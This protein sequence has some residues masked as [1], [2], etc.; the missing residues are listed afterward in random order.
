METK[1]AEV[2]SRFVYKTPYAISEVISSCDATSPMCTPTLSERILVLLWPSHLCDTITTLTKQVGDVFECG[3]CLD[4]CAGMLASCHRAAIR[5]EAA[6]IMSQLFCCAGPW[7][8]GSWAFPPAASGH[9]WALGCCVVIC[10]EFTR[11][12]ELRIR[13]DVH[14]C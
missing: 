5:S 1:R 4:H 9:Q 6:P 11:G 3:C 14:I 7:L 2:K 10:M 8:H 12:I 13:V